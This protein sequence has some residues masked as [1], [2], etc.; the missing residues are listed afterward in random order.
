MRALNTS[1]AKENR[2]ARPWP[3]ASTPGSYPWKWQW[4]WWNNDVSNTGLN[5]VN[6]DVT[7]P[8]DGASGDRPCVL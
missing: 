8:G 1:R 5:D 7:D 6:G 3:P 4:P 2:R